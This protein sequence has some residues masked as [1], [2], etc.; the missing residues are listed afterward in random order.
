M[1]ALAFAMVCNRSEAQDPPQPPRAWELRV[2]KVGGV[3]Y[4]HTR[5]DIPA[6]MRLPDPSPNWQWDGAGRR[7]L[8]YQPRLVPQDGKTAAVYLRWPLDDHNIVRPAKELDHLEFVGKVQGDG[9]A[10]MLLLYPRKTQAEKTKEPPTLGQVLEAQADWGEIP[11]LLDFSKAAKVDARKIELPVHL[12]ISAPTDKAK[13]WVNGQLTKS[14]GIWRSY[15]SAPLEPGAYV[16]HLKA[17]WTN[18]NREETA[19]TNVRVIPGTSLLV[20]MDWMRGM[21]EMP[22]PIAEKR[23]ASDGPW[24]PKRHD[25]AG[26]WA[27]AQMYQFAQLESFA[28]D[29]GFYDFA[30]ETTGLKYGVAL[31][32]TAWPKHDWQYLVEFQFFARKPYQVTVD[33]DS[34]IG[35]MALYRLLEGGLNVAKPEPRTVPLSQVQGIDPAEHPWDKKLA[36]KK[37]AIEPLAR[38]VPHDNYFIHF[39]SMLKLLEAGGLAEQWSSGLT[40]FLDNNSR[41]QLFRDRL[42]RQLCFNL[43]DQLSAALITN[44]V[45]TGSDPYVREGSD[46]TILF[47][48]ANKDLF[49]AAMQACLNQAKQAFPGKLKAGSATYRDIAI[50]SCVS[51]LRDI[52]LYKAVIDDLVILSNS[53]AG[54]RRV[55]DAHKGKIPSLAEA[56]DFKYMRTVFRLDDALEDGLVYLPDAFIRNLV[57]P[58]TRIKERRRLDALTSLSL[59]NNGALFTAWETGKLPGSHKELL[60]YTGLNSAQLSTLEGDMAVWDPEHKQAVS[61]MYNTRTFATPLIELPIENVT[62]REQREYEEFRKEYIGSWR[63]YFDPMGLRIRMTEPMETDKGETIPGEVRLES[64]VMPLVDNSQFSE[65]R[66]LTGDGSIKIDPAMFDGKTILQFLGHF[67]PHARERKEIDGFFK[68]QGVP[69]FNWLGSW[70]TLKLDDSPIFTKMV[71]NQIIREIDPTAKTDIIDSE[72]LQVPLVP[73]TLG[74]EIRNPIVF[75]GVLAAIKKGM[76][77]NDTWEPMKDP[78]KGTT[79][80]HIKLANFFGSTISLYYAL[81]DGVWYI[82][83]RP[84]CIHDQIDAARDRR[85]KKDT[86]NVEVNAALYASPKAAVHAGDALRLSL[87]WDANRRAIANNSLL[88]SFAAACFPRRTTKGQCA[89]WPGSISA[90]RPAAFLSPSTFSTPNETRLSTAATAPCARSVCRIRANKPRRSVGCWRRIKPC[91]PTCAFVTT[92]C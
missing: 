70:F 13:I 69:E 1:L 86:S 75:A 38:M 82:S 85:G 7:K 45:V 51:P 2:Q 68:Q 23:E 24:G 71:V 12:N 30:C 47:E 26:M 57:S 76:G 62:V 60:A 91:G 10:V 49:L 80:V 48:V 66:Q 21:V 90:S 84:E 3:T 22:R 34:I 18:G 74:V 44:V 83:F 11:L 63:Q 27:A 4:F 72:I 67:S 31:P 73:L 15:E 87:E 42:E 19:E 77:E 25:L 65:L 81:I 61:P 78:Y 9:P 28:P 39:K 54:I 53:P 40:W 58:A 41:G 56:R 59:V 89:T 88:C 37:P 46:L 33:A 32:E 92:A 5:V 20:R 64:F 79:L 6:D 8:A 29:G 43:N 50:E 16:Y 14:E 17:A 55:I 52:S 36:G 35:P